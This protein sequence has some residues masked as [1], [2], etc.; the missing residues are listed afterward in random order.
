MRVIFESIRDTN[1]W[2]DTGNFSAGAVPRD[3]ATLSL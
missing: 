3:T 2:N 1:R